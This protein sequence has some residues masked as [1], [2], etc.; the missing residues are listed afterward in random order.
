[1]TSRNRTAMAAIVA[2]SL[3][4]P[5][6]GVEVVATS[7]HALTLQMARTEGFADRQIE[8]LQD[9]VAELSGGQLVIEVATEWDI[10][11]VVT[12]VEQQIVGAV[13]AGDVDLGWVGSRASGRSE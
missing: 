13:A 8:H 7:P 2:A 6:P 4:A 11:G 3:A 12:D 10:G 1:M 9:A 5:A